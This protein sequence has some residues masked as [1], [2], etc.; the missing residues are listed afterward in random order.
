MASITVR[1]LEESTKRKLKVRAAENGR[2]MEQ[3][4]REILDWQKTQ[5]R[6]ERFRP[7][8]EAMVY[9]AF[10]EKNRALDI[11]EALFAKKKDLQATWIFVY[12]E[13]ASLRSEPRFQALRQKAGLSK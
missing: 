1:N 11:L 6:G 5:P 12:P 2:S 4:A 3:E 10:G 13:Y 8:G 7:W 9:A